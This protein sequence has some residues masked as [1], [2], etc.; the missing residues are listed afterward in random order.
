MIRS[1]TQ[2]RCLEPRDGLHVDE[3]GFVVRPALGNAAGQHPSDVVRLIVAEMRVR[4]DLASH[5]HL[6]GQCPPGRRCQ[7]IDGQPG[8]LQPVA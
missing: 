3:Q 4:P 2:D 1:L 7:R 8:E 5:P 6:D